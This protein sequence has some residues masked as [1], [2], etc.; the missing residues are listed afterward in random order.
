M[1]LPHPQDLPSEPT[2][3]DVEW[4]LS[5]KRL[6]ELMA[7]VQDL[8]VMSVEPGPGVPH[9]DSWERVAYKGGSE[10]GVN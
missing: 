4:H 2:A 1:P 9:P 8:D 6:C 3:L 5:V 10:P 7:R